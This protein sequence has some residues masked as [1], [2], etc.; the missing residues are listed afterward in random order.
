MNQRKQSSTAYPV[1]FLMV[2]S[3][4]HI[5]GK[6]GLTVALTISKN[7]GAF[8]AA[9]GAVT[10]LSSGWY[11]WAGNATD[12]ATLGELA[13]HAEATGADPADDKLVIVPYDPFAYVDANIAAINNN[14]GGVAGMDRA[15]RAIAVGTVGPGSTQ[16]TIN[17]SALTPAASAPNQ[18]KG[19]VL[20]FDKDTTSANLRSQK[21]EI[22]A[23][24]TGGVLTVATL[25]HSP[26]SGDTFTIT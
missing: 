21:T 11:A 9:A 13:W 10:E 6:T 22:T 1:L 15:E 2:D 8:A 7:G 3:A 12:R 23:S 26:V 14:T 4:D 5:A 18:F 20:A 24:D 17:T 16:T 25:S 19:Q